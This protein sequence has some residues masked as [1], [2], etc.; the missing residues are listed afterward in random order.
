M[1]RRMAWWAALV[2]ALPFGVVAAN[3]TS[4]LDF[5]VSATVDVDADGHAHVVDMEKASK[6]SD[7]P[8]L[9]PV[10]ELIAKRLGERIQTWQFVPATRNGVA[11]QS[12]TH[13]GVSMSASDD[14]RGGMSVKIVSASTGGTLQSWDKRSLVAALMKAPEDVFLVADLHYAADGRVTDVVFRDGHTSSAAKF[15]GR[16][17]RDFQNGIVQALKRWTFK[18]E[19]VDGMPIEGH[20]TLPMRVCLYSPCRDAEDGV[21]S[22]SGDLQFASADPAVKLRSAVAG[23]AL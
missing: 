22:T 21:A 18:P 15:V 10:A 4:S 3:P 9:V 5:G 16:A 7:V 2:L 1:M 19:I 8:A 17:D 13:L 11:V 23:T 6:L 14:G 20:G 12:R